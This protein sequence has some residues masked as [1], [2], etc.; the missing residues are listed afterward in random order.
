[1]LLF[2]RLKTATNQA[3]VILYF[4]VE[5]AFKCCLKYYC[6]CPLFKRLPLNLFPF[7]AYYFHIFEI[8]LVLSIFKFL[9]LATLYK[10]DIIC[11]TL[12]TLIG[13]YSVF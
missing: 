4:L 2:V 7:L 1:M 13:L 11:K 10:K 3:A 8:P 9:F 12:S 6:V 5:N